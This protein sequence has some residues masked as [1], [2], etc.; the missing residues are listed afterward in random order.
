M[1]EFYISINQ[2]A[3]FSRST[4]AARRRIIKQQ[5]TPNKVLIPW[6]QLA[7]A[8]SKKYLLD[9]KNSQPL[10]DAIAVLIQRVPAN[11]RQSTDRKVSIEALELVEIIKKP[12][13]LSEIRY[14]LIIPGNKKI[15]IA[16]VDITVAPDVIIKGTYKGKTIYGAV[17]IHICKTK[18]FDL[19]QSKYVSALLNKFL[20][21]NIAKPGE[22]VIP[23]LCL[24]MDV[25][26]QRIV[27]SS[28]DT[29]AEIKEIKRLCEEVK[30]IW[31]GI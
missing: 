27:S 8:A 23:Q 10:K 21:D 31:S 25:F 22:V 15:R 18:P 14:E 13:L 1:P 3:E 16:N 20:I 26:A 29:T 2:L 9:V 28:D 17:K 7:K 30:K 12:A 5:L 24:S 11:K 4:E 6:Y 19:A